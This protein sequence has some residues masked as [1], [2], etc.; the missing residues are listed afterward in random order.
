MK[1]L[2]FINFTPN[3]IALKIGFIEIRYYGLFIAIGVLLALFLAH[4]ETIKKRLNTDIIFDLIL[5]GTISGILGGRLLHV[6]SNLHYYL[7][8]PS[9]IIAIWN[10]GLSLHGGIALGLLTIVL[11]LKKKKINIWKYLD[12]LAPSVVL[13]QAIGRW[14]NFF[15]QEAFGTPTKLPWGI[16]IEEVN[17]PFAYR[18]FEYFHPTFFYEFITNLI[19]FFLLIILRRKKII[20]D[21]EIVLIYLIA[22]SVFR[23]IIEILRLDSVYIYTLKLEQI[24]SVAIIIACSLILYARRMKTSAKGTKGQKQK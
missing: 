1:F 21:G 15:N 4:K 10:G 22:Y 12:I 16:F 19:I 20:K 9:K 8:S 11:Y 23:F 2:S 14:G 3:P 24:L 13:A 7:E 17:R 18:N 5:Y 6:I